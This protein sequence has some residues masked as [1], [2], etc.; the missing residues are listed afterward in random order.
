MQY[1]QL[2]VEEYLRR[3]WDKYNGR[4]FTILCGDQWGDGGKRAVESA[5]IEYHDVCVRL[6]GGANTGGTAYVIGSDGLLH[7]FVFHLIPI[8]WVFGKPAI[9]GDRV[10]IDLTRLITETRDL[11]AVCG[12]PSAPLYISKKAPV[13]LRI[14]SLCEQWVEYIKG[15]HRIG[16][17]GRGI[18]PM[19]AFTDL[20]L[21][22]LVGHL[23]YP[24]LVRRYVREAYQFLAPIIKE[25]DQLGLI[26]SNDYDPEEEIA[27]L[28]AQAEPIR[29][30]VTDTGPILHDLAARNVPTLFGLT[31]G[32]GLHFSGTYPW[33]SATE[34]IASGAA[35]CCGLPGKYF[36]PVIMV[37]K[38]LPTRVGAGPFPT[39]WWKR[40]EAE[41][42]PKDHPELFSDLPEYDPEEREQFL[43]ENREKI[44]RGTANDIE[45]AQYF[46]V[47]GVEKGASTG[48][49]REVGFPDLHVTDCACAVNG[50]DSLVLTR[51]D[52]LSGLEFQLPVCVGYHLD[53]QPVPR[54]VLPT[55]AESLERVELDCEPL[56]IHL[57]GVNLTN[58]SREEA[59]PPDITR[60]VE[61][62][63]QRLGVPVSL[64]TSPEK[65]GKIFRL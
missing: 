4:A 5:I 60:L 30:Y 25:M 38:L 29:E 10:L 22:L 11:F 13:Y 46:M 32:F 2:E 24:D 39:G 41:Q 26:R 18:G 51:V 34:S 50:V 42:F 53:G 58:C 3:L 63:E 56:D 19:M 1:K 59:L 17:T 44:N 7:K 64:S 8:G 52:M 27:E 55:P 36:G 65:G 23:Y 54:F 15:G 28:L 31:Q 9:I 16:T 45:K 49:G 40:Q 14:H 33:N 37:S 20:R 35:Y 21:N 43:A 12:K 62:Y 61:F 6:Q 57:C 48:R 47:L